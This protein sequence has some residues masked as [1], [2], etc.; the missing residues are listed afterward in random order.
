[1]KRKEIESYV[2]KLV[3]DTS[4]KGVD[5]Y[6]IFYHI[7]G[8]DDLL[9]EIIPNILDKE[10]KYLLDRSNVFS[11]RIKD[12][13]KNIINL[14]Q[15]NREFTRVL[16]RKSDFWLMCINKLLG[17][18]YNI[19]QDDMDC[20][21]RIILTSDHY[22]S[23]NLSIYEC[24]GILSYN[25]TEICKIIY[26]NIKVYSGDNTDFY[27]NFLYVAEDLFVTN[28][29]NRW[30]IT[31]EHILRFHDMYGM[32]TIKKDILS[33]IV[34]EL[35][36]D[37]GGSNKIVFDLCNSILS[38]DD[39]LRSFEDNLLKDLKKRI[40]YSLNNMLS[41]NRNEYVPIEYV[42]FTYKLFWFIYRTR[43]KEEKYLDDDD[44]YSDD[45]R[46]IRKVL[47]SRNNITIGSCLSCKRE[48]S[49]IDKQLS[50][51][52]SEFMFFCDTKCRLNM[53]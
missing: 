31:D 2:D 21:A 53:K 16:I 32:T 14:L 6:N 7:L 47:H 24:I 1:M 25:S 46:N 8:D 41:K 10:K 26:N 45:S 19:D 12:L 23:H 28:I 3:R 29:H 33:F 9:T 30:F 42:P 15:I 5:T 40:E 49:I 38:D 17:Y 37:E 44:D 13:N 39:K 35:A 27:E 4:L 36:P 51:K 11:E 43:V 34:S 52:N 48:T 50:I 22:N 20:N 18:I